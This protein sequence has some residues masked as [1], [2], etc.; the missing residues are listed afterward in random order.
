MKR[1]L[2]LV[3]R[4][5]GIDLLI[6][7]SEVTHPFFQ[8][9]VGPDNMQH[10]SRGFCVVKVV[11]SSRARGVMRLRGQLGQRMRGVS[12]GLGFTE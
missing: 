8:G 4:A 2:R 9:F 7:A 12:K 5:T 3:L 6:V 10:A 1:E 11:N